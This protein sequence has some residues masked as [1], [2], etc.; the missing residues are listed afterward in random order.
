MLETIWFVLWG[1]LW[2]V[3]FMLDG[4]DLGLGLLHAVPRRERPGDSASIYN[5]RALLGRNEVWLITAGGATF[6]A[7]PKTYAVMFSTLYTPLMLCCSPDLPRDLVRDAG[8]GGCAAVAGDVGCL[9]DG[10]RFLPARVVLGVAFANIF[11][12]TAP[13]SAGSLGRIR[14][15]PPVGTQVDGLLGALPS[16]LFHGARRPV[17]RHAIR[18]RH[19]RP[20][21]SHGPP[22]LAGPVRGGGGVPCGLVVLD[23][24]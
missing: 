1:V 17:A 13:R 3:Y 15:L 9:H 4:F 18:G 2:A 20:R 10:G 24:A 6:A 5:A 19:L 12:G 22:A 7:F 8:Q 14:F 16:S 11:R 23:E 21:G